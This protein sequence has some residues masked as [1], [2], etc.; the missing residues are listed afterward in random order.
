MADSTWSKSLSLVIKVAFWA[1][2]RA[3]RR[4]GPGCLVLE[5]HPE[6]S[7]GEILVSETK[8]LRHEKS[9]KNPVPGWVARGYVGRRVDATLKKRRSADRRPC[10]LRFFL[11]FTL[12]KPRAGAGL[13]ELPYGQGKN[14]G[15]QRRGSALPEHIR[16]WRPDA[17]G[18]PRNPG[19]I[20]VTASYRGLFWLPWHRHSC[21]CAMHGMHPP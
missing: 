18:R 12:P 15:P 3:A 16:G 13:R 7:F 5:A 10:G 19:N 9:K 8:D 4:T 2:A 20:S 6:R 14:R 17:S 21:L 1:W 11:R